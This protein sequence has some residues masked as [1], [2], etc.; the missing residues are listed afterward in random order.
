GL[1]LANQIGIYEGCYNPPAG[2]SLALLS[3]VLGGAWLVL[4]GRPLLLWARFG[5][6]LLQTST[7]LLA[8]WTLRPFFQPRPLTLAILLTTVIIG[9]F[10]APSIN[11]ETVPA[12]LLT[13]ALFC[14]SRSMLSSTH[15]KTIYSLGFGFLLTSACFAR[16]PLVLVVL[17]VPV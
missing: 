5:G 9:W 15:S 17:T 12:F 13:G 6:I 14:L 4:L 3:D 16:F 10:N 1:H 2:A 7:A 8:Y 11:Y